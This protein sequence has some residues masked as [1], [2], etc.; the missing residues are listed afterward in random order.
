MKVPDIAFPAIDVNKVATDINNAVKETAYVAVG[1]GVLGFQK[2]Q[3]QRVE[4]TKQLEAQLGSLPTSINTR[5]E[6]YL[7]TAREQATSAREQIADQLSDLS[8]SVEGAFSPARAQLSK[9]I[10]TEIPGIPDFGQQLT[11]TAERIEAQFETARAQLVE[12]AKSVDERVAPARQQIDEQIDRLEQALPA[13][14]RT[15]VQSVRSTAT[16]QEQAVRSA[17]GLD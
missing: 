6:A 1:L 17:V 4:L 13:P 9:A 12:F 8:K 5:L 10:P 11:A 3:V 16:A 14:A 15:V 7:G 2:V